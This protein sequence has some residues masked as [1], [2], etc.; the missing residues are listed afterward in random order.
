[1]RIT[2][3][4]ITAAL[5]GFFLA[6]AIAPAAHADLISISGSGTWDTGTPTT[7]YSESGAS[8]YFS[9]ELP[10]PINQN[11]TTQVTNFTY[12]LNGISVINSLPGGVLFYS[13][14]Q[15]GGFDLFASLD[16]SSGAT[17][18]SLFFP[19]DVGSNLSL[20]FGSYDATIALNDGDLPG[21]GS[22][23]VNITPEPPSIILLGTALLL[24]GSL[25]YV[26]HKRMRVG[27]SS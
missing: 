9:F 5:S 10:D 15:E 11:P 18:I 2:K 25:A 6:L 24:S 13:V 4:R 26:R 3:T 14:A 23:T 16:S 22:G 19:E 8:W 21:S 7:A 17:I 1:M 20:V 12:D 27:L